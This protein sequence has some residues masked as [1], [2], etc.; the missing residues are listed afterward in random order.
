MPGTNGQ[1]FGDGYLSEYGRLVVGAFL[2]RVD[3]A[4]CHKRL[5][6]GTVVQT[7]HGS[8]FHGLHF[9]NLNGRAVAGPDGQHNAGQTYP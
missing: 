2:R 8:Q 9:G 5:P 7:L 4:E 1:P 6:A 3:Y